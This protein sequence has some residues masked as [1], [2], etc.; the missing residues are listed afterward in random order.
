MDI[1]KNLID[2]YLEKWLNTEPAKE[3]PAY[4]TFGKV[5]LYDKP[6]KTECIEFLSGHPYCS[7]LELVN[8]SNIEESKGIIVYALERS[9]NK[10]LEALRDLGLGKHCLYYYGVG[11]GSVNYI[12]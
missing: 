10:E 11:D 3:E 6:Y 8:E 7:C 9:G 4:S 1:T 2:D 12:D 5:A